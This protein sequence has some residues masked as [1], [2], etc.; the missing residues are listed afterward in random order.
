MALFYA[1]FIVVISSSL[2]CFMFVVSNLCKL[3]KVQ[4]PWILLKPILFSLVDFV[5][6]EGP[7]LRG[8]KSV[9][10]LIPGTRV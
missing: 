5:F 2:T 7:E 4:S 6:G 3:M 9:Q 8:F 1:R 10:R